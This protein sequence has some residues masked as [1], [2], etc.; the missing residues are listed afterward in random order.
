MNPTT[1]QQKAAPASLLCKV[2]EL[3]NN[4]RNRA[5]GELV[6]GAF[7]Y[8][9]RSCEYLS[10]SSTERKTKQ[11]R[12]KNLRFF[13]NVRIL[14]HCDPTLC[15]S[16]FITIQFEDQKNGEKMDEITQQNS[17]DLLLCPVQAWVKIVQLSG[18]YQEQ[19]K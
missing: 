12:L 11:L 2:T 8:A 5:I 4:A 18:K 7:F 19:W 9:M 14:Q 1:Q 10:V 6:I 3:K 13:R 16:D 15:S 17:G